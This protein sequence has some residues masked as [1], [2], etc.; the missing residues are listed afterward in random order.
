[1]KFKILI[2]IAAF[3]LAAACSKELDQVSGSF[4]IKDTHLNCSPNNQWLE[5]KSNGDWVITISFKDDTTYDFSPWA[6][7]GKYDTDVDSITI[8]GHGNAD[9]IQFNCCGNRSPKSR[10]ATVTISCGGKQESTSIFQNGT[11]KSSDMPTILESDFLGDWMELPQQ[12]TAGLYYF[13][14]D[15][16]IS[17][18]TC[19]NYSFGWDPDNLVALWVAYPLNS[20]TIGSGSRTNEWG[21]DPHVP[22][23]YQPV[24]YSPFVGYYDRGH[25]CPSA[26]RLTYD[27]NV[28]TFYGTNM[29]PQKNALNASAWGNLEGMVRKW[30]RQFDTLY[31]VTGCVVKG[32]TAKAYDNEGKAV[33]VPTGYYKALMGYKEGKT[34][35]D[36]GQ[37]GG[38]TAIGFYFEHRA[39]GSSPSD[40]MNEACSIDV[41]E[42]KTGLNFFYK[43]EKDNITISNKVESS[44]SSWWGSN[45]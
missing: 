24:L 6:Y 15:M 9:A 44:F 4:T 34:V 43:L 35:A 42:Q 38:Y 32:S 14:H 18:K 8:S 30:A 5:V 13:T 45:I 17:G 2:L 10:T 28:S 7:F 23:K 12:N 11:S 19:R 3:F 22:R 25:Q 31:V 29:T 37:Q 39:Y 41:L 40:I 26:D 36:T 33:A 27:A 16:T 20:F 21:L 1:M